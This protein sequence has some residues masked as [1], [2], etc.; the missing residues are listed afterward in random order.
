MY[1]FVAHFLDWNK[2]ACKQKCNSVKTRSPILVLQSDLEVVLTFFDTLRWRSQSELSFY[3]IVMDESSSIILKAHLNSNILAILL[4]KNLWKSLR[5]V[6]TA[7]N[8]SQCGYDLRLSV[9]VIYI[10]T[11]SLC[12]IKLRRQYYFLDPSSGSAFL[13]IKLH[14]TNFQTLRVLGNDNNIIP[15]S[16][17]IVLSGYL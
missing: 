11:F 15:S 6:L 9:K 5:P 1:V 8:F 7:F 10:S 14:W 2:L 3:W 16:H 4:T 17:I 12:L 13:D